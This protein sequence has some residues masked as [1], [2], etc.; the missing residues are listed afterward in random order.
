MLGGDNYQIYVLDIVMPDVNGME[1][2]SALR[3]MHDEGLII[4]LTSSV[5]YAVLSYAVN[6][7][8]Y[9]T[10]PL[11]SEKLIKVMD[12]DVDAMGKNKKES[13]MVNTP[14]GIFSLQL[15]DILYVEVVDRAAVF[16]MKDGRECRSVKLRTSFHELV[17]QLFDSPLFAA[18][19]VSRL[20][21]LSGVDAVDSDSVLLI[22][23]L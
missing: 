9:L 4:F 3:M 20:V 13:I 1:V 19:G 14:N 22:R 23:T 21:N 6:A 8:Y 18:C 16:Y 11:N 7:F 5:E 10:Q 12:K 15:K 2:A 17:P